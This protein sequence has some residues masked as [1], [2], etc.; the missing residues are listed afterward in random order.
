[1]GGS[2]AAI[3]AAADR[4]ITLPVPSDGG[5][6]KTCPEGYAGRGEFAKALIKSAGE[7]HGTAIRRFLAQLVQHRADGEEKLRERIEHHIANFRCAAGVPDDD[8]SQSRVADA[9]G[10]VMAAGRLAKHYG[11]L[12][13]RLDCEAVSLACYRLYRPAARRKTSILDELVE[14]SRNPKTLTIDASKLRDLTNRQLDQHEAFLH[15]NRRGQTELLFWPP[16]FQRRFPD[17]GRTLRQPEVSAYM[18]VDKDRV[19][20]K[21]PIRVGREDRVYCFVLPR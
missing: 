9:F 1:M 17:Y 3:A 14:I 13:K 20:V 7:Q 2:E 6:F 5:V 12:P 15:R 19:T 18:K 10:L 16:A 21:R 8:G 4:L 11:V